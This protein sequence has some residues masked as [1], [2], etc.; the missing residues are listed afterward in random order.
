MYRT[1]FLSEPKTH[2]VSSSLA[3][4]VDALSTL[5]STGAE[6]YRDDYVRDCENDIKSHERELDDLEKKITSA[7]NDSSKAAFV[8]QQLI[9]HEAIYKIEK[10]ISSHVEK[11][12]KE[13]L[14]KAKKDITHYENEYKK[15]SQAKQKAAAEKHTKDLKAK[16][17][18]MKAAKGNG[19]ND[20]Q[21]ASDNERDEDDDDEESDD[22]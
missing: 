20:G 8:K 11:K 18:A 12:H 7:N 21:S 4:A 5:L 13:I 17:E 10:D 2:A 9:H 16:T 3:S 1:V 22:R 19:Q 15:T 6:V 14:D